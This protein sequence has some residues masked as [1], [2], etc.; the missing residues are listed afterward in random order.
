MDANLNGTVF[1]RKDK[2]QILVTIMETWSSGSCKV[3]ADEWAGNKRAKFMHSPS[4]KS[5]QVYASTNNS[6]RFG[7]SE[8]IQV[9]R[10]E[11]K[12]TS[13]VYDG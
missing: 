13:I 3:Y 9:T 1:I 2:L 7:I 6:V 4:P 5:V 8:T 11:I 12:I 10:E